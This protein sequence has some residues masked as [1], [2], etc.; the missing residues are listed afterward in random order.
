MRKSVVS[1]LLVLLVAVAL[2]SGCQ[3]KPCKPI[4]MK[5][6]LQKLGMVIPGAQLCKDRRLVAA[7]DFPKD[8]PKVVV[9]R[10]VKNLP[11]KGWSVER[12]GR[13][14]DI[15][16]ATNKTKTNHLLII[17]GKSRKRRVTFAL[18]RYCPT[19]GYRGCARRLKLFGNA[20]K[21]T[22]K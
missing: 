20:F 7:F 1:K 10:F 19:R 14:K 18:V 4:P 8:S 6:H 21:K 15:L 11:T 5:P 9:N 16:F 13:R 22:S 3:A 17:T 12:V 2:F